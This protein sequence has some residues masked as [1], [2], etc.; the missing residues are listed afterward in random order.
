MKDFDIA[1]YLREHQLGSYSVLN[2]YVD[3]A[4]LKEVEDDTKEVELNTKIPYEGTE[5]KLTGN[6][7][8]DSFEQAKTVS[9]VDM[10]Q[11][12]TIDWEDLD[13]TDFSDSASE[14]AI[15]NLIAEF[16]RSIAKYFPKDEDAA[17]RI[18]AR[19]LIKKLWMDKIR[20][21]K[22]NTSLN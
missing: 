8:G 9:E 16:S 1:K 21:W 10:D 17:K 22:G 20:S 18:R 14:V 2:N 3:L 11:N 19:I 7:E 12:P 4:P 13:N 5:P 15:D 6:G